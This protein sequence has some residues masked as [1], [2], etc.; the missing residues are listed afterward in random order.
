[1]ACHEPAFVWYELMTT[2]LD[3]AAQF[4]GAVVGWTIARG[5]PEHSGGMD[6]RMLVRDDGGHAGGALQLTPAMCEHGANPCWLPYLQVDDVDAKVAAIVAEGGTSLMPATTLPVGR[7]AMIADPQGVQI[8]LMKPVPPADMPDATSD[9]FSV[10]EP[11]HVRWNELASPDQ[12]AS[13]DFYA[14]H[15]GFAYPDRMPM[16]DM[17]DYCFIAHGGVTLGAVMRQQSPTQPAA[18]LTYF[19]VTSIAAAK[20][21]VEANGGIVMM[22]P[23]EVPGGDWIIVATDPQGAVFGCVG[24]KG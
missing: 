8:Y 21:S 3:A 22:G 5:D 23:H 19:G 13:M 18:W 15:F 16:G 14:R 11:Q 2:D 1:M 20:S 24:P 4:Y 9:V 6:Y 7:I 10:T 12:Y 17:G